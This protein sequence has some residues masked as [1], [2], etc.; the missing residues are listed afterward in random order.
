MADTNPS[1][2]PSKAGAK[3]QSAKDTE[4]LEEQVA[5]LQED[6][7][8]ITATLSRMGNAKAGQARGQYEHIVED[9]GDQA[10]SLETQFKETVRE[11]PLTAIASAIGIGFIIALLTQR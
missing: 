2:A 7:K 5:R 6:L 8:S 9:L 10:A 3:A 11:K 1:S 4:S